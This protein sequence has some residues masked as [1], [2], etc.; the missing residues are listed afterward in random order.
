MLEQDDALLASADTAER[1]DLLTSAPDPLKNQS[2]ALQRA[3]QA[4]DKAKLRASGAGVNKPTKPG[5][6]ATPGQSG[7]LGGTRNYSI[8][9]K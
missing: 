9:G 3:A 2:T 7:V 4:R 5:A 6:G 1:T 8:L